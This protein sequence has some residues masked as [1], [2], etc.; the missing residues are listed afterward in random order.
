MKSG[1]GRRRAAK[2]P[3]LHVILDRDA[4]GTAGTL[5]AIGWRVYEVSPLATDA[6][7]IARAA[8]LGYSYVTMDTGT[9]HFRLA[10][11]PFTVV[12]G[13]NAQQSSSTATAQIYEL[14]RLIREGEI[15]PGPQQRV[16]ITSEATKVETLDG[17]GR[18]VTRR[19]PNRTSRKRRL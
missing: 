5:A 16:K 9:A 17:A 1:L 15:T 8:Q 14:R 19:I 18:R 4:A 2:I 11:L 3:K 7:N 6:E 12:L 10:A 13:G